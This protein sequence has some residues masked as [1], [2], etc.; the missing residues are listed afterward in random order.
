MHHLYLDESGGVE[1]P[2][3][4]PAATPA[5]IIL[6]L[7]VDVNAIPELTREFLEYKRRHF[8]IRFQQGRA[9]DHILIEVKGGEMLRL[10]R[11]DSRDSRRYVQ[12]ARYGLLNLLE[13]FGCR[14]VGRV[15]VKRPGERLKP[16]S[17][18][19]FSMQDIAAHF[20][21]YLAE[22]GSHGAIIADSRNP[23]QNSEVA[24]S[25][26]TQKWRTGEDPYRLLHDV[27]S[28]ADSRNHA[29]IQIADMLASMITLPMVAAAYGASPGTVHDSPRYAEVREKHGDA[30]QALQFR[31]FDETGRP[32][33]GIVVSDAVAARPSAMLF[34]ASG[35]GAE[36]VSEGELEIT[37][38]AQT[39]AAATAGSVGPAR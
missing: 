34:G 21:R 7:I 13:R 9:L 30:L 35:F 3:G 14:I 17:T 11:S 10:T 25:I 23:G 24:H 32:R 29:G 2:D 5:M 36:V 16:A 1:E 18:Y 37:I 8:A 22:K 20:M 19:G 31:Y 26:F 33:G 12:H 38:P 4:H 15:W 27:P 39:G 28:F 6:G